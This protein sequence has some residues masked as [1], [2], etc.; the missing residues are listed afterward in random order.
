MEFNSK[1]Y[2]KV[3]KLASYITSSMD[4][5]MKWLWGEALLGYSLD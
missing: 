5:K 2:E 1:Y 3:N 4:Y